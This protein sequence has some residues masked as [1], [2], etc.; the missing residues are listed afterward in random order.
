MMYSLLADGT[1]YES[2]PPPKKK[3]K[4]LKHQGIGYKTK[5]KC[6]SFSYLGF[7]LI[8]EINERYFFLTY[9]RLALERFII[10]ECINVADAY[11]IEVDVVISFV[12]HE[13][14]G[15]IKGV[16]LQHRLMI[17]FCYQFRETARG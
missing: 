7:S 8:T 16:D 1:L 9:T 4:K 13:S 3:K 5:I 2:P 11:W 6:I 17:F 12:F 10:M 15:M 14:I